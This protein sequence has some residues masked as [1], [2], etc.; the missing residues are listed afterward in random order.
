MG[1]GD[2]L[3]IAAARIIGGESLSARPSPRPHNS[4]SVNAV[5]QMANTIR[6]SGG[7]SQPAWGAEI[8]TVGAYSREGYTSRTFDVPIIPFKAQVMAM[9]TDEDVQLAMNHLASQVTGGAHYWKAEYD[10]VQDKLTQFS[11]D[12]DFD[13]LDNIVV[14][15][16]LGYGNTVIKPRLGINQVRNRDD[17]MCIPISSFVRVWWDRQRRPYKYEFRGAEYQGYHNPEDIIHLKWNPVNASAFGTGF[18][19]SLVAERDFEEVTPTGTVSKKLPS[20]LD[21]KYSTMMTMH[22]TERRYIPHNVYVA[23]TGSAD[24]RSALAADLADLQAGEDFVVG[25]K[26]EVQELGSSQRAFNP[27]QF[28]DLTQGAI[29][30]AL[31]D[32]RGKQASESSHQYANAK[33]SAVLDEIGLASFPLSVTNQLNEKLFQPWYE[34]TGG[35]Y[36]PTY[37]SAGIISVP[38][39]EANPQLNFGS[40]QKKD[41]PPEQVVALLNIGTTTGAVQDPIEIRQILE[42][43][44]LPLR[45]DYTDQLSQQYNPDPTQVLPPN[46]DTIAADQSGRPMDNAGYESFSTSYNP[47]PILSMDATYGAANPWADPQPS[48]PRINFTVRTDTSL[49]NKIAKSSPKMLSNIKDK[50]MPKIDGLTIDDVNAFLAAGVKET[51]GEANDALKAWAKNDAKIQEAKIAKLD[52]DTQVRE[53]LLKIIKKLIGDT[54]ADNI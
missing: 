25:N 38:W 23:Q 10:T 33:T 32:F 39:K 37:D 30:K 51:Q 34:Q 6:E 19:T 3:R 29:F 17:L 12:I 7:F 2:R 24:E 49:P 8:S 36:D 43:A 26:V 14:K 52:A 4:L 31:N 27:T 18:I 28:T 35:A 16:M 9:A 11:R 1:F 20:L 47:E 54:N 50:K 21:R 13:W 53:S 48:D 22:I 45:K 15:E 46:F 41:I 42:D 40:I 5:H 44:G